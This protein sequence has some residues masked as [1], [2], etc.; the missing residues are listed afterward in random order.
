MPSSEQG[1]KKFKTAPRRLGD[2]S[3]ATVSAFSIS[4]AQRMK[5]GFVFYDLGFT[6]PRAKGRGSALM[7]S[8]LLLQPQLTLFQSWTYD[9]DQDTSKEENEKQEAECKRKAQNNPKT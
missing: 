1:L 4:W 7:L 9:G 8:L 6:G 3:S 2:L 5:Y